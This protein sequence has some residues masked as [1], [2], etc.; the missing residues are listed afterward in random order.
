MLF[1]SINGYA[2]VSSESSSLQDVRDFVKHPQVLLAT[3]GRFND[4]HP[5]AAGAFARIAHQFSLTE[6]LLPLEALIRKMT[7][8]PAARL[9]L[10]QRGSV[11][12]GAYAD[13]VVLDPAMYRDNSTLENPSALAQGVKYVFVNGV[14]VLKD[15]AMSGARSGSALR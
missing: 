13:V 6:K 14:M 10:R 12:K 1:R 11:Q 2:P 9:G 3:D 8:L 5:R 4:S 7:T 15:A